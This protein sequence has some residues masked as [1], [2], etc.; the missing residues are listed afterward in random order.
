[1]YCAF[2]RG[3]I[4]PGQI[5]N[6]RVIKTAQISDCINDMLSPRN[7]SQVLWIR[8]SGEARDFEIDNI[9]KVSSS[10]RLSALVIH[11]S[12]VKSCGFQLLL[13]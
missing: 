12:S 3:A 7:F 13:S 8:I 9:S 11:S 6:E 4:I 1:M 2:C 5:N 10:L